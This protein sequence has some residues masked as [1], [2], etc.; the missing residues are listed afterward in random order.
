VRWTR[1]GQTMVMA[2]V[3]P[4]RW[5]ANEPGP[6]A[7]APTSESSAQMVRHTGPRPLRS[8]DEEHLRQAHAARLRAAFF[9][10]GCGAV[11]IIDLRRD[12]P[13]LHLLAVEA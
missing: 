1:S 10:H 7:S 5:H 4:E 9:S 8:V 3:R 11:V 13:S 2:H 6:L 12:S